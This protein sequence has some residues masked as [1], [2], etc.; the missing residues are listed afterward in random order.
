[1]RNRIFKNCR[2]LPTV[3]EGLFPID[4]TPLVHQVRPENILRKS[5]QLI[6]KKWENDE[7]DYVYMCSQ[8]KSIRQDLTVQHI[9]NGMF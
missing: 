7:V 8:L 6:N 2:N 9:K 1:M 3:R 4:V 5:I